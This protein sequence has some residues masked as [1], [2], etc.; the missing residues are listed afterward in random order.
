ML[1]RTNEE[2][3]LGEL[4]VFSKKEGVT[5]A[6]K[7]LT[8]D[9]IKFLNIKNQNMSERQW[10]QERWL[11]NK[12]VMQ[13]KS[14]VSLFLVFLML[15]SCAPILDVKEVRQDKP[16][17]LSGNEVPVFGKVIFIE[18]GKA[19]IFYNP[20]RMPTITILQKDSGWKREYIELEEDGSFYLILPRGTYIISD[21]CHGEYDYCVEPHLMFQIFE[22]NAFYLGTV[23]VDVEVRDRWVFGFW[24]EAINDIEVSDEFDI[25]KETFT[26]RYPDFKGETVRSLLQSDGAP[27]TMTS[28]GG[29]IFP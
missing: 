11:I 13:R 12:D 4:A 7:V 10:W 5:I 24:I 15:T 9:L 23:K 27:P 26:N 29:P 18:N 25:S 1:K 28:R 14:M 20:C 19:R 21:I 22:Y 17:T 2:S 3:S 16:I 8:V 6:K